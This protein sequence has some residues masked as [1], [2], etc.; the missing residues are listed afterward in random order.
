V[1]GPP[2]PL[3]RAVANGQQ[4]VMRLASNPVDESVQRST[5]VPGAPVP[6]PPP[7]AASPPA[8]AQPTWAD[9]IDVGRLLV[10]VGDGPVVLSAAGG[11]ALVVLGVRT[12]FGRRRDVMASPRG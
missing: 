12:M 10:A 11:L 3:D 7:H 2:G 4:A 5:H 8:G 6:M 1:S 9:R